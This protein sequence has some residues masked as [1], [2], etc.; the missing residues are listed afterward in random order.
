MQMRIEANKLLLR[1]PH[2][3]AAKKILH[4]AQILVSQ[5][6]RYWTVILKEKIRGKIHLDLVLIF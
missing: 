6:A 5:K 2:D 3:L 1:D 4:E